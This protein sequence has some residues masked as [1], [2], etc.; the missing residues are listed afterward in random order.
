MAE[1]KTTRD[2]FDAAVEKAAAPV[3]VAERKEANESILVG[4][5]AVLPVRDYDVDIVE[6]DGDAVAPEVHVATDAPQDEASVLMPPEGI[7]RPDL[8]VW[9]H[10]DGKRV[11]DVFS[12]SAS[13]AGKVDDDERAS[14]AAD[15]RTPKGARGDADKK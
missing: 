11:E 15:G 13:E 3:P 7:G 9:A 8:P 1:K 2:K 5:E 6:V 14:A 4:D 10:I 12:E